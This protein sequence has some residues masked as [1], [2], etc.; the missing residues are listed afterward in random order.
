MTERSDIQAIL[1]AHG[2]QLRPHLEG[3]LY[4]FD[5]VQDDRGVVWCT[6]SFDPD[7][8]T[9]ISIRKGSNGRAHEIPALAH[10]PDIDLYNLGIHLRGCSLCRRKLARIIYD[11][12]DWFP[13]ADE[14]P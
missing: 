10:V 5:W 8:E 14:Q 6:M 12:E 4:R 2:W 1:N 9:F 3:K 7:T 11:D 13:G